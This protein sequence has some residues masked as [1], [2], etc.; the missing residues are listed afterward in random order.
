V[1]V[2]AYIDGSRFT[3]SVCLHAA[4]ASL[5]L[6]A[7][8]ELIH[9]LEYSASDPSIVAGAEDHEVRLNTLAESDRLTIT[10]DRADWQDILTQAARQLRA[11]GV[12]HVRT[13]IEYG[14]LENDIR[15]RTT[16]ARLVVIGK[17]GEQGPDEPGRLGDHLERSIRASHC[18]MLVAPS[19]A[20]EIKRFL[21]AFD[22][23]ERSGNAVRF[24]IE[25]PLLKECEGTLLLAGDHPGLRHQLQDAASHLRSAGYQVQEELGHGDPDQLIPDIMNT[26]DIDLLVMGAFGHS[27]LRTLL[28]GSTTRRLLRS[29]SKA[30]LVA[31]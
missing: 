9:L 11:S 14:M 19:E 13:T 26:E 3:E 27:R 23:S 10:L 21:I 29:S 15:Q 22:G 4:W 1:S 30:I 6:N 8:A 12:E 5:K 25:Q 7:H 24:L 17:R 2:L 16:A 31:R 18:P 20:R 28:G